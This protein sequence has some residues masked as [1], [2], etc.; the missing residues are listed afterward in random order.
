[1]RPSPR[2]LLAISALMLASGCA[3]GAYRPSALDGT[4]AVI[5]LPVEAGFGNREENSENPPDLFGA[6]GEFFSGVGLNIKP[7]NLIFG[8]VIGDPTGVSMEWLA[9]RGKDNLSLGADV[10][11]GCGWNGGPSVHTSMDLIVMYEHEG[12]FLNGFYCGPGVRFRTRNGGIYELGPRLLI[13][14]QVID[15]IGFGM[16]VNVAPGYDFKNKKGTID[17][18]GGVVIGF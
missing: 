8:A 17:Y 4:S 10:L 13:G 18:G 1:M 7:R 12:L 3:T 14:G 11:V 15:S 2:L 5:E 6:A 16:T 9:W